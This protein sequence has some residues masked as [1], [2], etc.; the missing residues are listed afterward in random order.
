[1]VFFMLQV[2]MSRKQKIRQQIDK[3][4]NKYTQLKSILCILPYRRNC[5]L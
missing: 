5:L 2:S 4:F 1:M 3:V